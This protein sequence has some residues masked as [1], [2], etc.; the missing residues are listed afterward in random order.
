[1]NICFDVFLNFNDSTISKLQP[2]NISEF[3]SHISKKVKKYR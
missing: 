3:D 1:M 2:Y